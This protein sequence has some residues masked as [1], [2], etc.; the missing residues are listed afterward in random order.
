MQVKDIKKALKNIINP[1]PVYV[2]G[3]DL[4]DYNQYTVEVVKAE[5]G[6]YSLVLYIKTYANDDRPVIDTDYLRDLVSAIPDNY[7]IEVV[8]IDST[9]DPDINLTDAE[10][11]KIYSGEVFLLADY[12]P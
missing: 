2:R 9:L 10:V 12:N 3:Y 4:D 1:L 11:E 7:E 5:E 6:D 8:E